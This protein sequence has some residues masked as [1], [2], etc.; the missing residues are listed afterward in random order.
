[1]AAPVP[2]GDTTQATLSCAPR[3]LYPHDDVDIGFHV[4]LALAPPER[5]SCGERTFD[6]EPLLALRYSDHTRA[7]P[8]S[9][10]DRPAW[11]A[12]RLARAGRA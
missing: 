12:D 8:A 5:K 4:P 7:A 6:G 11:Q 3:L 9:L 10:A 2:L 1:M